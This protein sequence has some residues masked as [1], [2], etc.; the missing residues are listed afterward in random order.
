MIAATTCV[1][2]GTPTA[3][4]SATTHTITAT[5]DYG[6][7]TDTIS[8]EVTATG[9]APAVSYSGSPFSFVKGTAITT[10]TATL[11]GT[12]PTSCTAS[13]SLPSGLAI[14]NTSCAISGTP[15]TV[16]SAASYTITASNAYGS[17]TATISIDVTAEGTAP[18]ISYAGTPFTFTQNSA[19]PTATATLTGTTPTSCTSSPSLPSG[20]SIN[21][22]SCAITGTPSAAQSAASYT[23][24]AG[25]AYGNGQTDISIT[26]NAAG[27]APTVNF[28]ASP[29]TFTQNSAITPINPTLGGDAPT[30]CTTNPTLPNGLSLAA[31]T[32]AL[33]G[34]PTATQGTTS[35]TITA[36]NAYG[37]GTDTISIAVTA[38]G[39]APTVSYSGS[40][41][42]WEQGDTIT[43]QTPTISGNTFTS[44]T[45]SPTL[46]TGLTINTTNCAISG[47]P[48]A[49]QSATDH[50]ITATNDYGNDTTTINIAVIADSTAPAVTS[51]TPDDAATGV[52]PN[53][54]TIT[55]V[56]DDQ[57]DTSLTPLLTTE[58][59][60]GSAYVLIPNTGTTFAWTNST[61]LTIN[62]SWV[63]FPETTQL[64]WTLG[65][66][67]LKDK[68][69]NVIAGDVVRVF[70][71]I[72][73]NTYFPIADSGQTG[74]YYDDAGIWTIDSDC[75]DSSP[76][77][78][79]GSTTHP[80]G[81][82]GHYADTPYARSFTGPVASNPSYSNDIT[83]KEN[84]STLIWKTCSEGQTWNGSTC[85]GTATT[86]SWYNAINS[87]A[88]LNTTNSGAGFA[89]R[90]DWR[91]PTAAEAG[92]LI[93]YSIE[94]YPTINGDYFPGSP[95]SSWSSTSYAG[96]PTAAWRYTGNG[97]IASVGRTS[98]ICVRCISGPIQS[99]TTPS[100]S[101]TNG[102]ITDSISGLVWQKCS[103]GQANSLDCSGL[104][105]LNNVTWAAGLQYCEE[106]DLAGRTDWRLPT[107]NELRSIVDYS[108]AG[109]SIDTTYFS[110]THTGNYWSSTTWPESIGYAYTVNFN[111]GEEIHSN[112]RSATQYIR[113]VTGP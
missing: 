91:V 23:I 80:Y 77:Y 84:V 74:C 78:S 27:T 36:S 83:T 85:T 32:C 35:Y 65:A 48:T 112:L 60:N 51:S 59:W 81:Q 31:T 12:T 49:T 79:I 96:T 10:I 3:T 64:R 20:L 26:V 15:T 75:S 58:A 4:Q 73:R 61:T 72:S 53:T 14:S 82:D 55:V 52:A 9:T 94:G 41:Y 98:N 5:N 100:F 103:K 50:T 44:C 110:G 25:N 18:I 93:D 99:F 17:G 39:T 90:T 40:P 62:L 106:L 2:S 102:T 16:Q 57:M 1:I 76:L 11:T 108:K 71:T 43:T 63:Q 54:R 95:S 101:D 42:S 45:A 22:T 70:T 92:L 24:T 34:T 6:N 30:S 105:L 107:S 13:P 38:A 88:S 86:M 113:C 46:P 111:Y 37:S 68:S 21:A 29:Y 89:G 19:I 104:D 56:F 7:G 28:A 8:I 109:P 97:Q 67:N 66:V 33:S 87:C 69:A 47:T